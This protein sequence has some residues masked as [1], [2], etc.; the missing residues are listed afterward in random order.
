[1]IVKMM[2][3]LMMMMMLLVMSNNRTT[4]YA[5]GLIAALNLPAFAEVK[6]SIQVSHSFHTF[7]FIRFDVR[8]LVVACLSR[9]II[10]WK[11]TKND[12][13]STCI[14]DEE[15]AFPF[16][17]ILR[18]ML[19]TLVALVSTTVSYGEWGETDDSMQGRW[20]ERKMNR[21]TLRVRSMWK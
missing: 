6:I 5:V 19:I 1:M 13:K 12:H 16:V 10:I 3:F 18:R 9:A 21:L 20:C 4:R 11:K 14:K 15:H 17:S 7:A 2:I 8:T